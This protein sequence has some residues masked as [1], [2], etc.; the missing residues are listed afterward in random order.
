MKIARNSELLLKHKSTYKITYREKQ[1]TR[2]E[3]RRE[4]KEETS[5]SKSQQPLR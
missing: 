2:H 3:Y 5:L 4:R 1:L